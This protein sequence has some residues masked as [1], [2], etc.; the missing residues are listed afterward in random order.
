MLTSSHIWGCVLAL[1]CALQC[2]AG[3]SLAPGKPCG[4]LGLPDFG[5][6]ASK[7]QTESSNNNN[8]NNNNKRKKK[9]SLKKKWCQKTDLFGGFS[10]PIWKKY[11]RQIGIISPFLGMKND[12]K[13]IKNDFKPPASEG[14]TTSKKKK[15]PS[16][17]KAPQAESLVYQGPPLLKDSGWTLLRS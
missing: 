11:A 2:R 17:A 14:F 1:C 7:T 5:P 9:R 4:N 3:C 10:P 6:T 15:K 13:K 16:R 12:K 8:N